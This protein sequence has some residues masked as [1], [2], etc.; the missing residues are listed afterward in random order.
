M[1]VTSTP[2]PRWWSPKTQQPQR[3]LSKPQQPQRRQ[4]SATASTN[5]GTPD[6]SLFTKTRHQFFT[7]PDNSLLPNPMEAFLVFTKPGGSIPKL[8]HIIQL[9]YNGKYVCGFAIAKDA[10]SAD[11]VSVFTIGTFAQDTITINTSPK[12]SNNYSK[13]FNV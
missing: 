4:G 13:P 9:E 1:P 3:G 10:T 7:K 11:I 5:V 2:Q 12:A 8:W 6:R